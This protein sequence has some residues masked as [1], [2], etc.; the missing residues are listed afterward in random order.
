M[1][2]Q[3]DS[4]SQESG[5]SQSDLLPRADCSL[6]RN[7]AL[8]EGVPLSANDLNNS[9]SVATNVDKKKATQLPV[10]SIYRTRHSVASAPDLETIIVTEYSVP[11][12][13]A[14]KAPAVLQPFNACR[15]LAVL[16]RFRVAQVASGFCT[17]L[18][19]CSALLDR[20]TRHALFAA[21]IIGLL[22]VFCTAMHIVDC[23]QKGPQGLQYIFPG[24][25]V[26]LAVTL[27]TI[28][29]IACLVTCVVHAASTDNR[30]VFKLAVSQSVA[31]TPWLLV[32]MATI[33][34]R[35]MWARRYIS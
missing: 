16:L 19:G 22:C 1:S 18:L 2:S 3:E 27:T 13:N 17:F 20:D 7:G 15:P 35:V 33:A 30:N 23:R 21:C 9:A 34:L 31:L 25:H 29:V 14:H 11:L 6:R 26:T 4:S 10:P 5:P 12:T 24:M 8:S 28:G 32:E